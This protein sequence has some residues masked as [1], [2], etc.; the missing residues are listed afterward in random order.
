MGVDIVVV[1]VG[2]VLVVV[3]WDGFHLC[4]VGVQTE[5]NCVVLL[6][7]CVFAVCWH[8]D[9]T[10]PGVLLL[11][12]S[13]GCWLTCWCTFFLAGPHVYTYKDY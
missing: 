3:F 13:G 8:P 7:D 1:G 6:G 4:Y 9:A 2:V 11:C 12:G 10:G 5:Y